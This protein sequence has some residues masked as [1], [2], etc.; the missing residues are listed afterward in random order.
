MSQPQQE[1]SLVLASAS[2]RRRE[3]LGQLGVHFRVEPSGIDESMHPGEV[4]AAHVQ[5]LAREK[6]HEVRGRL[7]A[8]AER[9]FVLSAD[10]VVVLD[11][12]VYGKPLDAA[13]ALRMLRSLSGRTH[14]VLTALALCEV[15][16][17]HADE[18]L[19]TTE[20]SFRELDEAALGRY[21]AS[22]E[23]SDK[24]G[25]YAIQGLGAGLVRAIN[26]SYTNVV[27]LPAAETLE[28]LT[29]AGVLRSWP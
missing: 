23:A 4:A 22:G 28:I 10:T 9:P 7:Q 27:G 20:V 5:R 17:E 11:G 14:H 25:S 24:A 16:G 19:L 26:G 2:P 1:R 21:V 18:L 29:R 8:D 6:G 13:D 12:A 15:G 3:I